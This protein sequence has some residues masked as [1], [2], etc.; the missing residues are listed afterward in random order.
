M[1]QKP[2]RKNTVHAVLCLIWTTKL[3]CYMLS[4]SDLPHLIGLTKQLNKLET[5]KVF[6]YGMRDQ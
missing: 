6:S 4:D 5:C 3:F 1:G 2:S